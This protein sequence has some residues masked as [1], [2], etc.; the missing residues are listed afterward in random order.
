MK[1]RYLALLGLML[2]PTLASALSFA[3]PKAG[4][5]V[6]GKT[7]VG[8]SLQGE[9][10]SDVAKRFDVG[11]F[12]MREANPNLDPDEEIEAGTYFSIPTQYVLPDAPH[13]GIVINLAE[14]RLYYYDK[15]NNEVVTEPIGIGR[16][17]WETPMGKTSIVEKRA[18]P[19]WYAPESIRKARAKEGVFI[20][21]IIKPGPDNP[22]GPYAMRFSW[23]T[24]LMHGT[25]DPN[26][27][28]R[29]TSSGC[30]R[31]YNEDITSLFKLVKVGTPVMIVDQP[32][33][34]GWLD[35]NLYLEAH[36]PLQENRHAQEH[37]YYGMVQALVN[38]T[39]DNPAEIQWTNAEKVALALSGVPEVVGR[40]S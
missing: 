28:G 13:K 40:T 2:V 10:F 39:V 27:V 30:I 16:E 22:L 19:T 15:E 29:R 36:L 6:I 4:D 3:L 31:L 32:Y 33:K 38:A 17:G 12:E 9:T 25:N 35:G 7:Q 5:M 37:H 11:Y 8:M 26:G 20:P 23:R 1:K 14:L 24:Y 34:A 18:Q 21:H